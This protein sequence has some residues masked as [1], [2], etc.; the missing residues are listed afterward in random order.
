MKGNQNEKPRTSEAEPIE[1]KEEEQRPVPATEDPQPAI[2]EE[3][4]TVPSLDPGT[5][6]RGRRVRRRESRITAPAPDLPV[7]PSV[8]DI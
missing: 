1:E 7:P 5:G 6:S 8:L 4:P 2:D 3:E